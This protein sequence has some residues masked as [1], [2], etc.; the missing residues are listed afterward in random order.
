MKVRGG[1]KPVTAFTL[2][3][4]PK[5]LGK[6]MVRFFQNIKAFSEEKDGV[7]T[8]GWEWDEYHLE[9]NSY[10]GL[11]EDVAANL[12]QLLAQAKAIEDEKNIM[13]ALQSSQ[14]QMRSDIEYLSM[15]TEVDL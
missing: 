14:S 13:P 1:T 9:M 4:I 3:A 11:A 10:G 2:E 15:M 5:K 12:A 8:V 6:S 7:K